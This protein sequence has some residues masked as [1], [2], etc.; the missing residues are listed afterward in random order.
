MGDVTQLIEQA[1]AGDRG[2]LDRIFGLL[3]PE[4]RGIAHRRLAP[5]ERNVLLDT[6][7]LVN[8]CYLRFVQ[9]EGLR[10]EDRAHFLAYAAAVMRSIIV[11][12][13]RQSLA[14][15]RGGDVQHQPLD[16]AAADS[17]AAP[18]EEIMDVDSA[19]QQLA[20]LDARLAQVVEMRYFGGMKDAEIAEALSLSTRSVQ[21]AWDKARLLLAHT[22]RG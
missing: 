16:T 20:K 19:L 6:T 15:R 21:R 5:H 10:P 11:D 18:A 12:A 2:A 8:E 9:R 1:R 17:L 4:L 14:E 22:L 13:A 7:A 3:Y